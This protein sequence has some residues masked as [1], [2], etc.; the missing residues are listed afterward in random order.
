MRS[1]DETIVYLSGPMS[2][3]DLYNFPA[4]DQARSFLRSNGF[5]VICPAEG[6]RELGFDPEVDEWTPELAAQAS[7]RDARAVSHS[8]R[9]AVLHGFTS[10]RGARV[11]LSLA[12]WIGLP[13]VAAY[14]PEFDLS[15]SVDAWLAD[16]TLDD[17]LRE[18]EGIELP[19]R[20]ET[21]IVQE[22]GTGDP[23]RTDPG[24]RR[25]VDPK[26][27]GEKGTK[28][29]RFELLPP[30][31]LWR[32][33]ERFGRGA[34]K[35]EDRNWERGYAWSLSYGALLRH[36]FAWWGGEDDDPEFGDSHLAAVGFH[37]LALL[38]FVEHYP[39]GDDRP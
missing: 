24:E 31:A 38:H 25:V 3:H 13:V 11:E 36:L 37:A 29:A 6:D 18:F 15:D 39:D 14:A 28:L 4:F 9:V 32:I 22:S 5:A 7:R 26:T 33:A 27:G 17:D 23:I 34:A 20:S 10:S 16:G 30:E 1:P 19:S 21:P 35:Y 8:D 2:G 12:R